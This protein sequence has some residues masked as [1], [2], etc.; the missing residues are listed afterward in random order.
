MTHRHLT[1][2]DVSIAMGKGTD[3]AMDV[4]M[5]TLMTSDLL[6]LPKAFELS[7]QTVRLIHQNLFWAFIYN[8]DRYSYRCR[9]IVPYKRIVAESD[10]GK[11]RHGILQ[12]ECSAQF[13]EFGKKED[14]DESLLNVLLWIYGAD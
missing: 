10:A 5:V 9:S 3:I 4:A 7:R 8:S 12:C 6:L 2:A 1:L 11:C 13:V 14:L